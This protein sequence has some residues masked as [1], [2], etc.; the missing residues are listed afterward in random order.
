V[1]VVAYGGGRLLWRFNSCDSSLPIRAKTP[2]EGALNSHASKGPPPRR[3]RLLGLAA[4]VGV[5]MLVVSTVPAFAAAPTTATGRKFTVKTLTGTRGEGAKSASGQLA[6]TDKSL[7]GVKSSAP[8]NVVVKLDYDA[9][10]GYKGGVK[11]YA[12]TSPSV[13]G[14]RFNPK[15]AAVR[16]YH[17]YVQ[18]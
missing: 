10:A 17:G 16:H 2:R 5:L 9:L 18:R 14:E 3:R 6:R 8:V 4:A 15:D 7:L 13:T 1:R 11:G 12:A